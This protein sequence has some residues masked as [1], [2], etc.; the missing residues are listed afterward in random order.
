MGQIMDFLKAAALK[1]PEKH[2]LSIQIL[3]GK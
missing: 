2:L 1:T 3:I